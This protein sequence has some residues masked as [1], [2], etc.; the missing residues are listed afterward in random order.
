MRLVNGS[1]LASSVSK[2]SLPSGWS[3]VN[4]TSVCQSMTV[5]NGEVNFA[6]MRWVVPS[7]VVRQAT[8]CWMSSSPSLPSSAPR[9]VSP[10]VRMSAMV[11][12]PV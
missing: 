9:P 6:S 7:A 1:R 2:A 12:V 11:K 4:E 10:W 3:R 5:V 8:P